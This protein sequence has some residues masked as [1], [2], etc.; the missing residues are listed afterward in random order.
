[1][2]SLKKKGKLKNSLKETG[3]KTRPPAKASGQKQNPPAKI[4]G[5]GI[6]KT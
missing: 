2:S 4:G 1:M 5:H 6:L 3:W